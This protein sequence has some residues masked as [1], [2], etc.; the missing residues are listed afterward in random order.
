MKHKNKL[1]EENE[2]GED[3]Q[4]RK[5]R[6]FSNLVFSYPFLLYSFY[7]ILKT[8][9]SR[10]SNNQMQVLLYFFIVLPSFLLVFYFKEIAFVKVFLM[11]LKKRY[12]NELKLSKIDI[13][14][15]VVIFYCIVE[16]TII[17]VNLKLE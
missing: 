1:D 12:R 10:H 11:R 16:A 13:A 15:I 14:G 3:A 4:S 6:L 9:F 2:T 17:L 5:E 8:N 7:W